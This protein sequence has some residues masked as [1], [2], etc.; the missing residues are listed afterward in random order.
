[1]PASAK[2][3]APATRNAC[4]KVILS[5][6]SR[7]RGSRQ[8][9]ES[10]GLSISCFRRN[11]GR[12]DHRHLDTLTGAKQIDRPLFRPGASFLRKVAGARGGNQDQRAAA[13]GRQT[14]LR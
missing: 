7:E 1:M 2:A 6:P 13:V 4:D 11:E 14:A 9:L 5:S 8:L 10:L 12:A 3:L